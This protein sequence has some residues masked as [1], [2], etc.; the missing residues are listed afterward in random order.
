[1]S[2]RF[3]SRRDQR[4]FSLLEVLVAFAVFSLSLGVL[5]QIFSSGLQ[6][7]DLARSYSQA[8]IIAESQLAQVSVEEALEEGAREGAVDDR[9]HWITT[10]SKYDPEN[11]GPEPG[12]PE[13]YR[14]SVRVIW[15]DSAERE[16]IL[17]TLRLAWAP[18]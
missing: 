1:L 3:S 8:M 7:V 13:A 2:N 17:D 15:G 16:I 14:I 11:G 9:Y 5:F 4:G 6:G 10:V 18:E 12:I